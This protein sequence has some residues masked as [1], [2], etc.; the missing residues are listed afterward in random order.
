MRQ[1]P[2]TGDDTSHVSIGRIAVKIDFRLPAAPVFPIKRSGGGDAGEVIEAGGVVGGADHAPGV[3]PGGQTC[4]QGGVLDGQSAA[5]G[6]GRENGLGGHPLDLPAG[7]ERQDDVERESGGEGCGEG[8]APAGGGQAL[9]QEQYGQGAQGQ[10]EE[11]QP[12][13]LAQEQ[14]PEQQ[15]EHNE[16]PVC[17]EA[18]V[19]GG[20]REQKKGGGEGKNP[21]SGPEEIARLANGEREAGFEFCHETVVPL[22]TDGIAQHMPFGGA[23][24]DQDGHGQSGDYGGREQAPLTGGAVAPESPGIGPRG[25]HHASGRAQPGQRI[26]GMI[27]LQAHGQVVGGIFQQVEGH[28]RSGARQPP[29][30]P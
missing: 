24:Q 4:A 9:V 11:G 26:D 28:R 27:D 20:T 12:A 17:G 13:E 22:E 8:G 25:E 23:G 16:R 14:E 21:K 3:G 2:F 18:F 10:H 19:A 7:A 1:P 15:R 5:P 29:Y 30:A 6:F